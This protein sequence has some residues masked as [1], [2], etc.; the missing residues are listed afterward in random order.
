[1]LFEVMVVV[2]MDEAVSLEAE[3]FSFLLFKVGYN[4]L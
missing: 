4:L 2:S 3:I 1:M